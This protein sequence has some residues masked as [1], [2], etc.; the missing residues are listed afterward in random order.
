MGAFHFQRTR[1]PEQLGPDVRMVF[2][3]QRGHGRSGE[4]APESYTLTQLGRDLQTVLQVASC[5]GWWCWWAT[6]WAA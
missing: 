4:A 2:Y 5:A 1:L 3:D 6:R